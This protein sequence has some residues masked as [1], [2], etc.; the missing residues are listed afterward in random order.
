MWHTPAGDRVLTP[1]EWAL[2]RAALG[3]AWDTVETAAD[4]GDEEATGVRAFDALQPGQQVALLALVGK[5]LS[6]PTVVAPPLTAATEGAAAAVLAQVREWL[7]GNELADTDRTECRRLILAAVGEVVGRDH[8]LPALTDTDPDEWELLID[9]VE[10][11]L[12]WDTDYA[13]GDLFLDR[14]PDEV[15]PEMAMHGIEDDY[16]TAVPD[17]PDHAG[18]EA[19]RRALAELTG[20]SGLPPGR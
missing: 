20:R 4:A 13:L 15:R 18:L 12:L 1:G 3:L 7:L 9:E 14:S 2:V 8:P 11:R 10:A 5:A 6:D 19:A 16:F 17:D